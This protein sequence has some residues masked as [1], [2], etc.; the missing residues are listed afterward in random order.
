MRFVSLVNY[1]YY[2]YYF[3][4]Y[5]EGFKSKF[6]LHKIARSF[7]ACLDGGGKEGEWRGVE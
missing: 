2:Y 7:M 5:M 4:L 6:Y 3:L 1:Y